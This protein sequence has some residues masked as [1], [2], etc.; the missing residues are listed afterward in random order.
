M[1]IDIHWI[2]YNRVFSCKLFK[3]FI[4]RN[5]GFISRS[6]PHTPVSGA[7]STTSRKSSPVANNAYVSAPPSVH[8]M[9]ASEFFNNVSRGYDVLFNIF[10]YLKVQ[11][12]IIA[13]WIVW[14]F[15]N[16][17]FLYSFSVPIRNC[18]VHQV[19]AA[20]GIMWQTIINYGKRCVWRIHSW[21]IGL[22]WWPHWDDTAHGI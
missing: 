17:L 11:V 20:C 15:S 18:S 21:K 3:C 16:L 7:K 12:E 4:D 22:D 14:I 2:S 8:T 10:Q 13:K 5:V 1:C 6:R 9:F 19:C